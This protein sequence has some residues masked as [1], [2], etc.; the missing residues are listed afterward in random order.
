MK[1]Y[2]A[3]LTIIFF[4]FC[5]AQNYKIHYKLSYKKDSTDSKISTKNMVLE[6]NK[7]KSYFY[8]PSDIQTRFQET[9]APGKSEI[10]YDG[11]PFEYI[12]TVKNNSSKEISKTTSIGMNTYEIKDT[13]IF[14]WKIENEKKKIGTYSCQK[15]TLSFSGRQ[16]EAWFSPEVAINN[17]PYIFNGLPGLIIKIS[18]NKNNFDFE[19]TGLEKMKPEQ[20]SFSWNGRSINTTKKQLQKLKLDHY[21]DPYKEIR[22]GEGMMLTRNDSGEA[23]QPNFK[24]SVKEEQQSLKKNNNPLELLDAVKYP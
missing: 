16:W 5:N 20:K 9:S 21:S 18:D 24:E 15:A 1:N 2:I 4:N 17:G 22:A 8:S 14:N 23:V 12:L 19:L 11:E 3:F 13:P 7:N 6:I 10:T